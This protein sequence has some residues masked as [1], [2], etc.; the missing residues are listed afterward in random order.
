MSVIFFL[1]FFFLVSSVFL[2]LNIFYM[3]WKLK[4]SAELG[5]N[6]ESDSSSHPRLSE[7]NHWDSV[8]FSFTVPP[9]IPFRLLPTSASISEKSKYRNNLIAV[10][11]DEYIGPGLV[12]F[13]PLSTYFRLPHFGNTLYFWIL[14]STFH[15]QHFGYKPPPLYHASLVY[16]WDLLDFCFQGCCTISSVYR[17]GILNLSILQFSLESLTD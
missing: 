1:D 14:F 2:G 11:I 15:A 3:T 13:L 8:M 6:I 16:P 17:S 9:E 7:N 12:V 4:S 10:P 5:P